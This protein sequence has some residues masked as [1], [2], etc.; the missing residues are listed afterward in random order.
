M[1]I[2]AGCLCKIEVVSNLKSEIGATGPTTPIVPK[3]VPHR[4]IKVD[5]KA[6]EDDVD[7]DELN[8]LSL[9]YAEQDDDPDFVPV[10]KNGPR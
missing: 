8:Q 6:E 7:L 5:V 10:T 9:F 3:D 1:R 2:C 4:V